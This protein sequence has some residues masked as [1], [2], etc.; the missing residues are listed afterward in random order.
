ME[1]KVI[2]PGDVVSNV[3]PV[4]PQPAPPALTKEQKQY[5]KPGGGFNFKED[6]PRALIPNKYTGYIFAGI[7]VLVIII[8]IFQFPLG[9]FENF[10]SES[11]VGVG[12]PFP[13]LEFSFGLDDD[14]SMPLRIHGLIYDLLI[15]LGISYAINVAINV[16]L[17]SELL[18]KGRKKDRPKIYNVTPRVGKVNPTPVV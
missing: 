2:N 9:S 1:K 6:F 5:I 10:D 17:E 12:V 13:F 14:A 4:S 16:I 11:S 15:Y 3:V 7:F 8:G 18:K